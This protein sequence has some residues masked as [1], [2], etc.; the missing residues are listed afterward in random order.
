M[1]LS[2]IL[3][4]QKHTLAAV[5]LYTDYQTM[6]GVDLEILSVVLGLKLEKD[7]ANNF[8]LHTIVDG[9]E[10][11]METIHINYDFQTKFE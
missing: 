9:Y 11:L 2:F 4:G 3:N 7:A 10:V 1:V 8:T 5:T 6:F